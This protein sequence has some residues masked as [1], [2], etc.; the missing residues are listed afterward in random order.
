MFGVVTIIEVK[1]DHTLSR[2]PEIE[3]GSQ[4]QSVKSRFDFCLL[5]FVVERSRWSFRN[6]FVSWQRQLLYM[7]RF[8]RSY[9]GHNPCVGVLLTQ[10][11]C[12]NFRTIK[13]IVLY[14]VGY[15]FKLLSW[16]WK[17]ELNVIIASSSQYLFS[18]FN[19]YIYVLYKIM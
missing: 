12:S 2:L 5:L 7:C 19:I 14:N 8:N 13:L 4:C 15:K 3:R 1:F 10:R 6:G 16:F 18:Y 11:T 17:Q 9:F